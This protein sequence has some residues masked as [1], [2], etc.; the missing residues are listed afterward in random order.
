MQLEC[1][2]V[3]NLLIS[4]ET[5]MESIKNIAQDIFTGAKSI[6]IPLAIMLAVLFTLEYT[7]SESFAEGV[8]F[9]G[10]IGYCLYMMG[11]LRRP[12]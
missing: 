8:F 7:V 5:H 10:I 1:I 2:L 11:N 4:Q 12:L 9:A 3:L 6:A